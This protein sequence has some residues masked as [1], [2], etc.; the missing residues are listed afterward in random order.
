MITAVLQ[1][2]KLQ[3]DWCYQGMKPT[4]NYSYS[5][6]VVYE[7]GGFICGRSL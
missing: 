2:H 5:V 6:R 1:Q 4:V 7:K 3:E